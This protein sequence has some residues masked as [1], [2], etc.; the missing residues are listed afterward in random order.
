MK[1]YF[2]AGCFWGTQAYF[3]KVEGV[4]ATRAVYANG[5]TSE[6]EY[7]NLYKTDHAETVE[8]VYDE[9]S[10]FRGSIN[11][12]FRIVDPTSINKQGN[13]RGR[14]YRSAIFYEDEND[15]EKI[16]NYII[17]IKNKYDKP[18]VT[19]VYKISNLVEAEDYHQDYLEKNPGGYCHINLSD[20]KTT[21]ELKIQ[22]NIEKLDKLSYDVTQKG[23]T[24]RPFENQYN[25]NFKEGIYVDKVS[26]KVLFSSKD[27]FESGCGWP[28]F[29]KPIEENILEYKDDYKLSRK[30]TE[31]KGKNLIPI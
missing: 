30:R 4:L 17:S 7:R 22:E 15:R 6:T 1:I 13:D 11:A 27:K 8:V 25:N 2:A 29:S 12:F 24:E 16:L 19:E 20:F 26:R 31:V 5:T 9:K 14:Q 10:F 21:E 23:A 3:K 28:A 18:I